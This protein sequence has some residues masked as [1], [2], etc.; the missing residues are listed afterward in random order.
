MPRRIIELKEWQTLD[1]PLDD[2]DVAALVGHPQRPVLV[3]AS[4]I[5]GC[6]RLRAQAKVGAV[7]FDGFDL[8]VRPKAGLQNVFYLM[9]V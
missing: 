9:G 8:I 1:V 6:W 7:R 5:R 2:R 3:E 4:A